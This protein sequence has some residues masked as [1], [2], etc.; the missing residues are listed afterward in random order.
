ME[1]RQFSIPNFCS[2]S[3]KTHNKIKLFK[4]TVPCNIPKL[5]KRGHIKPPKRL[6]AK[7]CFT[8]DTYHVPC[9]HWGPRHNGEPCAAAIFQR[10][11]SRGCN[12]SRRDGIRR[13]NSPCHACKR[14][15]LRS[16]RTLWDNISAAARPAIPDTRQHERSGRRPWSAVV[17]ISGQGRRSSFA[18]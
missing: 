8:Q 5:P 6:R 14:R 2:S 13:I 16:R 9:G 10:G 11:L 3:T 4:P 7:M 15:Q 12:N 1:Y 17:G 18:L